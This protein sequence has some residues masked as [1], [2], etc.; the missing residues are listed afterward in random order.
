MGG[1]VYSEKSDTCFRIFPKLDSSKAFNFSLAW[2]NPNATGS[3]TP[4]DSLSLHT[5]PYLLGI[6]S[7]SHF[8]AFVNFSE[9]MDWGFQPL[10]KLKSFKGSIVLED[11]LPTS[12]LPLRGGSSVMVTWPEEHGRPRL[13]L[14]WIN[15]FDKRRARL[16]AS[17]NNITVHFKPRVDRSTYL[18]NWELPNPT[19]LELNFSGK[20]QLA[21][22]INKSLYTFT[23]T[24]TIT[25]ISLDGDSSTVI[26]SLAKPTPIVPRQPAIKLS[27]GNLL[28]NKGQEIAFEARHILFDF[29][30]DNFDD[31]YVY[32]NPAKVSS[33]NGITFAKLPR[34]VEIHI[35][36]SS[37]R[38]L[39]SFSVHDHNGAVNW[40]LKDNRNQNLPSGI[41]I[42]LLRSGNQKK[43]GKFAIIR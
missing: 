36:N 32:P 13:S 23:P 39:R 41:Y 2:K 37:G 27:L 31:L 21:S 25:G 17:S 33:T 19:R 22:V 5:R 42:Y 11:T 9:A 43:L 26:L 14:E 35:L 8:Q 40:D 4:I 12:I 15:L 34:P 30:T 28:D 7:V 3:F 24:R 29:R 18:T 16:K 10:E 20:M 6:D 1:G 38:K